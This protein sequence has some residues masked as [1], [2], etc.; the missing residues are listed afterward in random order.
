MKPPGLSLRVP[1]PDI[2]LARIRSMERN[3]G[4]LVK[5]AVLF[6]LL[7]FF[8]FTNWVDVVIRSSARTRRAAPP[9]WPS[10]TAPSTPVSPTT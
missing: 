9:S 3:V 10:S 6:V 7:Y 5:A 2:Q 4:L 8:F 1:P